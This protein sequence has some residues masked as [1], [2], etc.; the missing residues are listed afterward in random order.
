MV[1]L[2][3]DLCDLNLWPLTLIFCMDLSLVIG[4]YSLKFHDDTMMGT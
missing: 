4:D 2:G 1:K 3:R